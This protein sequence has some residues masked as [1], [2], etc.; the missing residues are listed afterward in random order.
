MTHIYVVEF[1][2]LHLQLEIQKSFCTIPN[3]S[4]LSELI[5]NNAVFKFFFGR[6]NWRQYRTIKSMQILN[7]L[8]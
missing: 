3:S 8:S 2:L 7:Q 5:I 1:D 6:G 4:I